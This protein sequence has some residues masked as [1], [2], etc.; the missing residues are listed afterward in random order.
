MPNDGRSGSKCRQI[1]TGFG[2]WDADTR[3]RNMEK[4]DTKKASV[5]DALIH[6]STA[7]ALIAFGLM[8]LN[9][10]V[11]MGKTILALGVLSAANEGLKLYARRAGSIRRYSYVRLLVAVAYVALIIV[12]FF[13]PPGTS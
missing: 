7:G 5:P 4:A 9:D 11:I 2:C 13:F 12:G 6:W 3:R 1:V 10:A 8:F